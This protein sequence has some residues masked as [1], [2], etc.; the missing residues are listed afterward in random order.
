MEDFGEADR[1]IQF[2]TR[3]WGM[4]TTLAKSARKSK[5]RYVGGLDLFCHNEISVKGDPKERPYLI[6]LS[7]LNSFP[8]LREDLERMLLAGRM[9]QWIR[10]LANTATPM[11]S[12]YSLLGQ[13]LS[14]IENEK[15]KNRFELLGL[16]FK[17]K[18][19][20]HLGFKPKVDSCARCGN[21]N[22][23]EGIFDLGSGGI[24]CRPCAPRAN[25]LDTSLLHP[26]QRNFLNIADQFRLSAW[27]QIEYPHDHV[28]ILSR[29]VTQFASFH[30]H[31]R[32][33]L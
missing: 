2:F 9:T 11:P 10:N 25:H 29:I 1:Y 23:I 27:N 31:V 30:T 16:V 18:L 28:S 3:D 8:K 26:H 24:L 20:S 32:L 22:D 21:D 19:L 17:L 14:L 13:S 5:R 6:E 4:I 12:V 7:V 33:P 15:N